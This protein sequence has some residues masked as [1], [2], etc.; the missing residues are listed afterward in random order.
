[1]NTLK[2]FL[3]AVVMLLSV[4]AIAQDKATEGAKVVA[5]HMKEKLVLNE[6]QY[7][8]VLEINKTFLQKVI[9]IKGSAV[10]KAEKV[11]K[12]RALNDERDAKLKS[13]L[14]DDQYKVYAA[15]R[16]ENRQKLR[17][18]YMEKNESE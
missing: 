14:T 4:N 10:T 18:Y 15:S 5:M 11:K 17:E 12:V 6:S 16:A 8:K 13:V 1:M 7:G 3:A 9:A 2:H